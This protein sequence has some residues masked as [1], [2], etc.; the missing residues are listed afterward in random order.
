MKYTLNIFA[1]IY[2]LLFKPIKIKQS[3]YNN[4][5]NTLNGFSK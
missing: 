5:D 4:V 2:F 3:R 1:N